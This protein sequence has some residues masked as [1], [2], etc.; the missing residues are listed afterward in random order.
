MMTRPLT[1][2]DDV[3]SKRLN[4]RAKIFTAYIANSWGQQCREDEVNVKVVPTI[5]L[6]C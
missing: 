6:H 3:P 4:F 2:D 5:L 1:R